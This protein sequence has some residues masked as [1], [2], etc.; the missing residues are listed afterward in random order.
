VP[1]FIVGTLN[2]F[3]K[4]LVDISLKSH[5]NVSYCQSSK[6]KTEVLVTIG[7]GDINRND[8][9]YGFN[10]AIK[11]DRSK[12]YF[13][14]K[15]TVN[16]LTEFA[17]YADVSFGLEPGKLF[18]AA[19]NNTPMTGDKELIGF[20]GEYI[21]QLCDD[22]ALVEIEYIEFTDEFQKNVNKLDTIWIKPVRADL[23][24]D[25][26]INLPDSNYIYNL[27][28]INSIPVMINM[29]KVKYLDYIAFE[30]TTNNDIT[31]EAVYDLEYKNLNSNLSLFS[32]EGTPTKFQVIY[33]VLN[34]NNLGS[35]FKLLDLAIEKNLNK[36]V[37]DTNSNLIVSPIKLSNCNCFEYK[38][39]TSDIIP[40]KYIS[41]YTSV[42]DEIENIDLI[43]NN[44]VLTLNNS[45]IL[46]QK[47]Q[48]FNSVG[49]IFLDKSINNTFY[50][51]NIVLSDGVYFV[52]VWTDKQIIKRKYFIYN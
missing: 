45:N 28:S 24:Y 14:S 48:L 49:D 20:Y 35:E 50:S 21:G 23:N 43:Y 13:N 46:I 7:L 30:V 17:E 27:E 26:S 34:F 40:I 16:T 31:N 39:V 41:N 38:N 19:L 3:A 52:L 32:Y 5:F 22:S 12:L 8:S 33:K 18:G 47:I 42:E 11:Y 1:T 36:E 25:I 10:F 4:V 9:L 29:N 44:G 37:T 6:P 2:T 15:I 51:E